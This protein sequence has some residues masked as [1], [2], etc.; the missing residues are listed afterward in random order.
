MVVP[1]HVKR[2]SAPNHLEGSGVPITGLGHAAS[3]GLRII[4]PVH[5]K[6]SSAPNHLDGEW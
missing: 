3:G 1:V 2:S 4:V 5:F 6:G